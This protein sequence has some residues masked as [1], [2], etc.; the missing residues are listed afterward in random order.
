MTWRLCL[1][2]N[3]LRE[4]S[5]TYVPCGGSMAISVLIEARVCGAMVIG[6]T[7]ALCKSIQI[8]S[9]VDCDGVVALDDKSLNWIGLVSS[10]SSSRLY[11]VR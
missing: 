5:Q 3:P 4:A 6:W 9:L 2:N 8:E 1:N 7:E 10:L 11:P